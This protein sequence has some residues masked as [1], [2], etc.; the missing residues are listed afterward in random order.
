ML[1]CKRWKD[2]IGS[3]PSFWNVLFIGINYCGSIREAIRWLRR[4][5]K[6]PLHVA[7]FNDLTATPIGMD[8]PDGIALVQSLQ[9]VL[10][11]I[12]SLS[13]LN[14]TPELRRLFWPSSTSVT[15]PAGLPPSTTVLQGLLS[16]SF[17]LCDGAHTK[18]QLV[19]LLNQVP[20]LQI[21][22]INGSFKR[23]ETDGSTSRTASLPNLRELRL[24]QCPR[25]FLD[26][27][28]F[29]SRTTVHLRL[30]PTYLP[31]RNQSKRNAIIAE[32]VP[33]SFLRSS[34]IS[35]IIDGIGPVS[36]TPKLDI[37]HEDTPEGRRC[38]IYLTLDPEH[39]ASDHKA[40]LQ[41]AA[42]V[43]KNAKSVEIV[44]IE[45]GFA[46]LPISLVEWTLGFPNLRVFGLAGAHASQVLDDPLFPG[47]NQHP[48]L[49]AVTIGKGFRSEVIAQHRSPFTGPGRGP[50][51]VKLKFN[52]RERT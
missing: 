4:S 11:R 7:M 33:P 14:P 31:S 17:H 19:G 26:L 10:P 43:L 44:H 21:L 51:P 42:G 27:L 5:G 23:D 16:L 49:Q 18:Q 6:V 45:V 15:T 48:R 20:R 9:Q 40:S 32:S 29:P 35:L 47:V 46:S 2:I 34:A 8:H 38:S 25:S 28:V 24:L 13:L 30:L 37:W 12:R 39:R 52:Q 1:V 22:S 50:C 41:L 3:R 36:P